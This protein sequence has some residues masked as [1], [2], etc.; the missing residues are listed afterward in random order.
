MFHSIWKSRSRYLEEE[1]EV[2]DYYSSC[3]RF[4]VIWAISSPGVGPCSVVESK[5]IAA[6][7]QEILE[8][9]IHHFADKLYEDAN[10]SFLW[11]LS[12]THTSKVPG[13]DDTVWGHWPDRNPKAKSPEEDERHQ[14][15]ADCYQ[16][17][18]GFDFTSAKP[19]TD[20]QHATL[21][22]CSDTNSLYFI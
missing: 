1:W 14:Q 15:D 12:P 17:S 11:F 3:L 13:D 9:F 6:S 18:L 22:W 8:H 21:H 19:Q 7:N 10:F 20:H 2:T 16:S 5:V 4:G